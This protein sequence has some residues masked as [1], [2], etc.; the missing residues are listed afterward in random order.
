MDEKKVREQLERRCARM[1]QCSAAVRRKALKA[2]DGDAEAAERVVAA[3]VA[4][5]YVD[6]ARYAAAFAREKAALSGWGHVKIRYA[7][8]GKGIAREAIDAALEAVEPERAAA[9]LDRVVREKYRTLKDD[10]AC[11]L[12]LLKFVL[13]RG[14]DYDAADAAIQQIM[15]EER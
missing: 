3:L 6:D 10:P 15:Q 14:Y 11:R 2:L 4:E 7:L 9:R 5:G 12:K 8:A 1:E 13:G